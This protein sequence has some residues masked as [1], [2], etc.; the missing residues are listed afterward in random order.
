MARLAISR[1]KHTFPNAVRLTLAYATVTR[2]MVLRRFV[3]E[4]DD[5]ILQAVESRG[6]ALLGLAW[7]GLAWLGLACLGL[8][9]LG[10]V[11]AERHQV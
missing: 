3:T 11:S 1:E 10:L 2:W 9:C 4:C 7:L 8:P 6:L 5:C